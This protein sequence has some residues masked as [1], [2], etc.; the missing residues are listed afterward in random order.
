MRIGGGAAQLSLPESSEAD[1]CARGQA[2]KRGGIE[3]REEREKKAHGLTTWSTMLREGGDEVAGERGGAESSA[4]EATT[5]WDK[6][7]HSV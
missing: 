5:E 3:A 7:S 1:R 4:I 6:D 2:R